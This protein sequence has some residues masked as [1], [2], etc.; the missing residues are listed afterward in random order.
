[1]ETC[2]FCQIIAKKAPAKIFYE[3]ECSLAFPNLSP[4]VDGH[5]MVIPKKHAANMLDIN[6]DDLK[7]LVESTQK[8]AQKVTTQY[9]STGFNLLMANGEDAQQSVS[10]FH[11]HIVPRYPND[12]LDLWIRQG[13]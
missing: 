12:G 10:H 7:A 5:V 6:T 2:I 9:G 4:V 13:L 3:D 1:M 8:V 11:W